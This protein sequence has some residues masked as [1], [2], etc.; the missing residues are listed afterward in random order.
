MH[1]WGNGGA[2]TAERSL[3]AAAVSSAQVLKN[4]QKKALAGRAACA[5][6]SVSW[7]GGNAI[8]YCDRGLRR[9]RE[10]LLGALVGFVEHFGKGGVGV[11]E[12][13]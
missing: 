5:L 13:G 3:K 8:C 2:I 6:P 4:Q 7:L 9:G 12:E 1:W 11:N 10:G